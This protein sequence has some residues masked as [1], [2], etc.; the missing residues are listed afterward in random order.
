MIDTPITVRAQVGAKILYCLSQVHP[1]CVSVGDLARNADC[2]L[3]TI[4]SWLRKFKE[5]R[6]LRHYRQGVL[7]P[8]ASDSFFQTDTIRLRIAVLWQN[9]ASVADRSAHNSVR[10]TST[11]T[12]LLQRNRDA[13][14][15]AA[16]ANQDA[17]R[18]R[19]EEAATHRRLMF[20]ELQQLDQRRDI[21]TAELEALGFLR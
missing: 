13:L 19:Y 4:R 17:E 7:Q 20:T 2:T 8:F 12:R 3:S 5:R 10:L 6:A 15:A 21:I 1:A 14:R 18:R 9:N 11:Q 16:K